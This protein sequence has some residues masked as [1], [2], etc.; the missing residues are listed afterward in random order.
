[1]S[2][3]A[4]LLVL[5]NLIADSQN[6]LPEDWELIVRPEVFRHR[7][8]ESDLDQR[9]E[10]LLD[11]FLER[12]ANG[13]FDAWRTE[14]RN[15]MHFL[16]SDHGLRRGLSGV[17][18]IMLLCLHAPSPLVR[19]AAAVA[20]FELAVDPR[21]QLAILRNA[22]GS[23]DPLTNRLAATGLA[24]FAPYRLPLTGRLSR[25][26][27][28]VESHTSALLHGTFGRNSD[29]W[30]PGGDY[31]EY[32]N[33]LRGDVYGASDAFSWSGGWS[34]IARKVAAL[35]FAD[36]I[37]NKGL[38]GLDTYAHSHGGNVAMLATQSGAELGKLTLL[39]CPVINGLRLNPANVRRVVSIRVRMDLVLLADGGGQRFHEPDIQEIVLPIW[40]DHF[41]THD[42]DVWKKYDLYGRT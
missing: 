7:R 10:E 1:M 37:G 22:L 28:G 42:P 40:F 4:S 34:S 23:R 21:P 18:I 24:R 19:L 39:S 38:G 9:A 31:F 12:S 3:A 25:A 33:G 15:W 20:S 36:W 13:S 11:Q 8:R 27:S 30:Q 16:G 35:E 14:V 29:W 32:M 41:A 2:Q 5:S 6:E 17:P 26:R